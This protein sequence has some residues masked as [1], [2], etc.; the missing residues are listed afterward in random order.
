MYVPK[1]KLDFYQN[2]FNSFD[3]IFPFIVIRYIQRERERE[4][5]RESS[6]LLLYNDRLRKPM[7]WTVKRLKGSEE[8][9]EKQLA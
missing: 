1:V 3:A 5:E 8:E 6:D 2:G 9:N 4:R 7:D